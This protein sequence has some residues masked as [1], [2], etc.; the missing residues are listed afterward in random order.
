MVMNNQAKPEQH[1]AWADPP[2]RRL[3]AGTAASILGAEIAEIALPLLALV[4]FAASAAELSAV[5]IAQFL[6][7]LLVTLPLGLLVD[8]YPTRRLRMMVGADLGRI[9]AGSC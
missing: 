9:W 6:P 2:F 4:T 1:S 5:R 7:F 3:W 8:R